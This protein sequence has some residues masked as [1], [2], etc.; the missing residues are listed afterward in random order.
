MT[1]KEFKFHHLSVLADECI[2]ALNIKPDGIYVDCTTGGAGHSL[3][4]L[5]KLGE[6]GTLLCLD[7][8]EEALNVARE[9]LNN[10]GTKAR[11]ILIKSDFAEI[12]KVLEDNNIIKVSGILADFGVS[13]HQ[14]DE[15]NRGFG[16]MQDG[17]LDMR[18]DKNSELTA[19]KIVNE[20]SSKELE[21]ILFEYGEEKYTKR[22]VAAMIKDRQT[23]RIV[24]T[25]ELSDII[26]KA[27]PGS[28]RREQQHPAK[29]T[30]QAVRIEVNRELESIRSLVNALPE[31]L[32]P[33][34]RFAAISFHSLEDRIIKETLK[35]YENPCE[36][37]KSFP[38]CICGKKAIGKMLNKKPITATQRELEQNPRARSA[39]LRVFEKYD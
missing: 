18:M 33:K 26:T 35:K 36:C 3:M 20:Y 13:S 32:E 22:I 5:Q 2:D 19:E 25:G 8:D 10:S 34:G 38:M 29:R 24:K 31:I 16:Y 14:L 12:K 11:F 7:K 30:F 27:I 37:P 6:K 4:I 17:P 15:N 9:R 1:L 23:K 28:G 21:K 39:K